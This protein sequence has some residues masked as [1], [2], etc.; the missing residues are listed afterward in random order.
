MD[1]AAKKIRLPRN[2]DLLCHPSH[3]VAPRHYNFFKEA[4]PDIAEDLRW[5]TESLLAVALSARG[6]L[7][8][9]PKHLV[10]ALQNAPPKCGYNYR[11][12]SINSLRREDKPR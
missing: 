1:E 7:S 12:G 9:A 5:E 11:N 2:G 4:L 8:E 3:F 10:A 6:S